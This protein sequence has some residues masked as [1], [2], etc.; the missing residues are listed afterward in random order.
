M[1]DPIDVHANPKLSI[2]DL[3]YKFLDTLNIVYSENQEPIPSRQ[4]P[5]MG[6]QGETPHDCEQVS[7][8]LEQM[9]NG[10]PGNPAQ[11]ASRCDGPRTAVFV[12]ELVRCM[13]TAK[14]AGRGSTTLV[15]PTVDELTIAATQQSKDAWLLMDA[16]LR[17]GESIDWL[18]SMADISF[19]SEQ[20]GYQAV[21]LNWIVGIP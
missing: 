20:G 11:V 13:P 1:A 14:P 6:G 21:V 10:P 16:A 19:T 12:V 8:S 4:F 15:P 2:I 9:Y 18:G 3:M 17:C 7:I 5:D